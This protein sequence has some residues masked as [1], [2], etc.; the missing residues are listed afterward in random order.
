MVTTV[1]V[2]RAGVVARAVLL[3][4]AGLSLRTATC[5]SSEISL[6]DSTASWTIIAYDIGLDP[7]ANITFDL[8]NAQ[9]ANDTYIMVLTHRQWADWRERPSHD[10][11]GYLVSYWRG[12]FYERTA[13]SFLVEAPGRDRYHVIIVNSLRSVLKVSGQLSMV[14]AGGKQLPLQLERVPGVLLWTSILFLLTTLFAA[15]LVVMA[16]RRRR[17][18]MHL[19]MVSVPL[20]RSLFLF[21]YWND[22]EQFARSGSDSVVGSVVWQLLEKVQQIMERMMFLLIALGWKFMRSSLQVTEIR[23]AVG[24]SVISFYLG[25][26]E[27]ACTTAS[28]CSG[29]ELSRQILH[30]LCDLVVIVAMNF[31]LQMIYAE[32]TEAPASLE[33]G[34]LY[35]KHQAY[36]VFRW[37]VLAYIVSSPVEMFAKVSIVPWHS[38]MLVYKLLQQ[39]FT[40]AIYMAV[41]VVFRPEPSP[42]RVFELTRDSHGDED[43]EMAEAGLGDEEDVE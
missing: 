5:L 22:M 35:R 16:S 7:K 12:R 17:T 8:R 2:P 21:L 33:A 18:T 28:T 25:V 24:V 30:S 11:N 40:W 6:P 19:L 27:V 36:K 1:R 15:A 13:A 42:L 10:N 41:F 26:F 9:P 14:N 43:E 29:Y 39:L 31:S 34:K 37:I 4:L 38:A 20:V 32:I 23:F 3:W